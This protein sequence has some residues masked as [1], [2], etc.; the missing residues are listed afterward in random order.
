MNTENS[1]GRLIKAPQLQE[2][3]TFWGQRL[4][5]EPEH[6]LLPICVW[7]TPGLGKTQIIESFAQT[8]NWKLAYLAPAQF[9]EMGD[10]TGMPEITRTA[11]GHSVTQLVP[12]SWVPRGPG[13]GIL[14]IDDVNR[15]DERILRGIMQLLQRQQLGDWSLPPKWMIALTANPDHGDFSVARMDPALMDRML[16]VQLTFDHAAWLAWAMETEL[17]PRAIQFATF[18]PEV[19]TVKQTTPRSL[20]QFF[21]AIE[22]LNHW[23][24]STSLL[25]SLGIGT[26]GEEGA[27]MFLEFVQSGG[28]SIPG[29]SELLVAAAEGAL[30]KRLQAWIGQKHQSIPILARMIEQLQIYLLQTPQGRQK[31]P[32]E[33][34]LPLIK[35]E[36]W[37]AELR[38][39]L[40]RSLV[41][42]KH[43]LVK[44]LRKDSTLG[45]LLLDVI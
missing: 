32:V 26:L 7:G 29:P 24:A 40:L 9:E 5:Q 31:A 21:T 43:P 30:E 13:P 10:L 33:Q 12:P 17:D 18:Y 20:T 22:S 41:A 28:E 4:V 11:T 38:L 16:H 3:L 1:Y 39:Q 19:F 44:A 6:L 2:L 8:S 42:H 14:L 27:A 37:P 36:V 25:L 35:S 15:A 34:V 45:L 23:Q